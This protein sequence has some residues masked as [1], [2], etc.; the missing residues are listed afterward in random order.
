MSLKLVLMQNNVVQKELELSLINTSHDLCL[1]KLNLMK[2]E[3]D[4]RKEHKVLFDQLTQRELEIITLIS[5]GLNSP[6][7]AESLFISRHTV[8]QHR[9]NINRKLKVRSSSALIKYALAFGIT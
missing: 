4:F 5:E 7:I 6:E 3:E 9:K 2:R 8:E 1:R